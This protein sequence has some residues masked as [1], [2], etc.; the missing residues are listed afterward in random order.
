MLFS[1]NF[2][3]NFSPTAL[4]QPGA[5]CPP[6]AAPA[7]GPSIMETFRRLFSCGPIFAKKTEE[8]GDAAKEVPVSLRSL[9]VYRSF[10]CS[11]LL[12]PPTPLARALDRGTAT[13]LAQAAR[14]SVLAGAGAAG[15]Q[16]GSRRPDDQRRCER[17]HR[18]RD[19]GRDRGRRLAGWHASGRR[20][21]F[22]AHTTRVATHLASHLTIGALP[23][24]PTPP[25]TVEMRNQ[26]F[27]TP[28]EEQAVSTPPSR[29][30]DA[31][32]ASLD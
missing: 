7:S 21:A 11:Q 32:T 27:E 15:N 20:G 26:S 16:G 4:A 1:L 5:R 12:P 31:I 2:S 30:A 24:Q 9:H 13:L 17:R 3:L 8:E 18:R 29:S 22:L 28:E 10:P 14:P 6:R 25:L 19:R 23:W